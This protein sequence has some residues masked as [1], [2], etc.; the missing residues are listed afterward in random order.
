MLGEGHV[1][2]TPKQPANHVPTKSKVETVVQQGDAV[3][4][5]CGNAIKQI[6]GRRPRADYRHVAFLLCAGGSEKQNAYR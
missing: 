5:Y 1:I 2:G 4:E 3:C 6:A